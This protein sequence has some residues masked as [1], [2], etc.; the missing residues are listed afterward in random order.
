[1]AATSSAVRLATSPQASEAHTRQGDVLLLLGLAAIALTIHFLTNSRYGYHGDELCFIACGDHLA[2]GYVDQPPLVPFLARLS[3]L[4]MGDS[5]FSIR[6]FSALAH[7]GLVFLTGWMA[8]TLGGRRF[9]Q[10]LVALTVLL[11]PVFLF[12]GNVLTTGI[13]PMWTACG[14]LVILILRDHKPKLWLWFGAAAGIGLMNKHSMLFWGF[15]LTVGLLLMSRKEFLNRW[16]WIGAALALIIAFPNVV[17]EQQHHWV[18]LQALRQSRDVNRLPF[19]FSNFWFTQVVL[20]GFLALP[21]WLAWRSFCFRGGE[22]HIAQSA[23]RS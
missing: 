1:M 6:F 3:R 17:W 16:I 19:S 4:L 14:F 13:E 22:E 12:S 5:L 9:A 15:G 8:R 23:S 21:V 10:A 7:A 20:N 2:W 11:A 18:T